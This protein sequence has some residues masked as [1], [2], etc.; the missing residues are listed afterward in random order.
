MRSEKIQKETPTKPSNKHTKSDKLDHSLRDSISMKCPY[1]AK[2]EAGSRLVIAEGIRGDCKWAWGL[3]YGGWFRP[4][5]ILPWWL[6]SSLSSLQV[7]E[8]AMWSEMFLRYALCLLMLDKW[9][10]TGRNSHSPGWGTS[11]ESLNTRLTQSF[12]SPYPNCPLREAS[13]LQVRAAAFLR[14]QFTELTGSITRSG[15]ALIQGPTRSRSVKSWWWWQQF[16]SA[17]KTLECLAPTRS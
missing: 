14:Q 13:D 11:L 2:P 6:P 15:R 16:R 7:P 3:L 4:K 8:P 9:A 12:S 5:H 10:P 17:I 1:K